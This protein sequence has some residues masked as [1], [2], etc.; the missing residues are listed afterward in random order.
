MK[1][2]ISRIKRTQLEQ[3]IATSIGDIKQNAIST[4]DSIY[5]KLDE[6]VNSAEAREFAE[7]KS[8]RTPFKLID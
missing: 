2:L 4:K 7:A 1:T 3:E 5:T 6:L 8:L